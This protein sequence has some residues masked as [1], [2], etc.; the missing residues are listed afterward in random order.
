MRWMHLFVL[1]TV[2]CVGCTRTWSTTY[3]PGEAARLSQAPTSGQYDLYANNARDRVQSVA[4]VQG[5]AIG[6]D[7]DAGG[8]LTAVAGPQRW[9]LAEGT[10]RWKRP[11]IPKTRSPEPADVEGRAGQV[12]ETAVVVTVLVALYTLPYWLAE[13]LDAV[14]S[15]SHHHH[16]HTA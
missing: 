12:A 16:H 11:G 13:A 4:V 9:A 14:I 6:F 1:I 10:Y 5:E 8:Q 7:R 15:P 3:N 2:T